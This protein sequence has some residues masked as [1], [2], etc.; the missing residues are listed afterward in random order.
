V[1]V[2]TSSSR[3]AD[4]QRAYSLGANSYFLKPSNFDEFREMIQVIYNYWSRAR[5]PKA[6]ALRH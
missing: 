5:R 3:D 1:V 6:V 4:V 2:L